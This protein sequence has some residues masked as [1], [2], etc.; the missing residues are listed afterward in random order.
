ME[1]HEKLSLALRHCGYPPLQPPSA[2]RHIGAG[3]WHDVYLVEPPDAA[4]LVIRLR[5]SVIYGR[6]E[7]WHPVAL[8]ADYAPVGLYYQAANRCQPGVCPTVYHYRVARDLV[9]TVE[10][11]VDGHPLSLAALS[12]AGAL[13]L[14]VSP[15]AF[16][17]ALHRQAA[18]VPGSGPL[19]WR[20]QAVCATY[21]D[22]WAEL[23][24]RRAAAPG[25]R[26]GYGRAGRSR[27]PLRW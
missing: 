27:R 8:H 17:Q 11:Y 19:T 23:W 12:P 24:Q 26:G 9:C 22:T 21:P 7:V 20:E 2:Y 1:V 13:A 25:D 4:P 5:K 14:G 6:E 10:S 16:F 15:G 3:A 18:P